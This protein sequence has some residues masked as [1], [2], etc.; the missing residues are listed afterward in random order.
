MGNIPSNDTVFVSNIT[1]TLSQLISQLNG[2]LGT[3]LQPGPVNQFA[4]SLN[5]RLNS[6]QDSINSLSLNSNNDVNL[7]GIN[8][9]INTLTLNLQSA[10]ADIVSLQNQAVD[11]MALQAIQTTL[12]NLSNDIIAIQDSISNVNV[13][14]L[15]A[16]VNSINNQVT[17]ISTLLNSKVDKTTSINGKQLSTNVTLTKT[18]VGLSMVTN[19]IQLKRSAND[20]RSFPLRS[21]IT[22]ADMLLLEDTEIGGTKYTAPVSA[23]PPSSSMTSALNNKVDK[24]N[25]TNQTVG[26]TNK[27]LIITTNTDGQVTAASDSLINITPAQANLGNV[28]NVDNTNIAN[29]FIKNTFIPIN[30]IVAVNDSGLNA[31]QK[32]Q[33]QLNSRLVS[34]VG[35]SSTSNGTMG[36]VPAP[37]INQEN[38]FLRGDGVW[39]SNTMSVVSAASTV[40]P[41]VV[42]TVYLAN[43]TSGAFNITLPSPTLAGGKIVVIDINN[44]FSTNPVTVLPPSGGTI[45]GLTVGLALRNAVNE[46]YFSL[47]N[48]WTI[49]KQITEPQAFTSD[50][51]VIVSPNPTISSSSYTTVASLPTV[52]NDSFRS[53]FIQANCMYDAISAS[54][55]YVMTLCLTIIDQATSA[56]VQQIP[57]SVSVY[58]SATTDR[59][60]TPL[61]YQFYPQPSKS[62][63]FRIDAML[64]GG[65]ATSVT[66][67]EYDINFTY[68]LIGQ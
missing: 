68:S 61:T 13:Q 24:L 37:A 26:A 7:S 42:N 12:T 3:G 55:P 46:L 51:P 1:T 17:S 19:D 28:S 65:S 21:I 9:S 30:G 23:L 43:T 39:A 63:L 58:S 34:M 52:M 36:L 20:Y 25:I 45:N 54:S 22:P 35:A 59:Y 44:N 14:N 66:A 10:M 62:Y 32:L 2:L 27:T 47:P 38:S 48:K 57:Q 8:N 67:A 5:Q 56:V 40:N 53:Y 49:N 18:D 6:L 31:I 50:T 16:L 4:V 29:T 33:G 64:T 60:H 41:G 15:S 11:S